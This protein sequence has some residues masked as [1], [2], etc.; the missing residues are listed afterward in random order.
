[1]CKSTD[2]NKENVSKTQT[3]LSK[4]Q[5][6]LKKMSKE[7]KDLK[8][9]N[10]SLADD[11]TDLK[12]RSMRDNLV[13][14]GISVSAQPVMGLMGAPGGLVIGEM[15]DS[16]QGQNQDQSEATAS[17]Q[18]NSYSQVA[19]GEDCNA[20][21][22]EF[23]EQVLHISNPNERV[24]I[25]RAHRS[26]SFRPDKPRAMS[27]KFK[28]TDSKMIVK[29]AAKELNLK[30][31]PFGVFDQYPPEVQEKR[32]EL[33]PV[34]LKAKTQHRKAVLVRDKLYIYNKLYEPNTEASGDD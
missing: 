4:I 29:N 27:V 8:K 34:M 25:D 1:M 22:W 7:N 10:E 33:I 2:I 23:C 20:K 21:V 19:A 18:P 28:D 32:R 11:I 6:E 30:N 26:G 14:I 12:C 15:L 13:L 3:E 24:F 17:W 9:K 5:G 31:T 16:S